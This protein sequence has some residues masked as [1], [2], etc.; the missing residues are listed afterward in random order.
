MKVIRPNHP[1]DIS[2]KFAA[3]DRAV[4]KT[5][6]PKLMGDMAVRHVINKVI[7]ILLIISKSIELL[8]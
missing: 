5:R 7:I 6:I 2:D 3:M 4:H 8:Y 1:V